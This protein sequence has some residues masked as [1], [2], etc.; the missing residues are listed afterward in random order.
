MLPK[1]LNFRKAQVA[2]VKR[3][4]LHDQAP[5]DFEHTGTAGFVVTTKYRE[6][7]PVWS[8]T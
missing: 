1:G 3:L 6:K 5:L 7:G 8:R 4:S 2:N